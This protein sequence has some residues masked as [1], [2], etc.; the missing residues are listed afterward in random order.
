[1]IDKSIFREYDIRG[2]VPSQLNEASI[3]SISHAI[4]QKCNEENITELALGR[5]GRLSGENILNLLS[6]ELQSTGIN[7][8]N[9]GVVSSPL[10]YY[11]AKKLSSKSGIMITGS[12][13]PKNYNGLKIVINDSPIS[14]LEILNLLSDELIRKRNTG[15]EI[16]KKNLMDEYIKEVLSQ[17]SEKPKEIKVVLDCGNGSAG[18]IAPK[19]MRS[20]GYEVIELYCEIDG[21]FPNHHPDPG[22][23]E[24]LQ[25]LIK[26]VKEN[27]ADAGIAFDGDGD[28]LG[29]VTEE[30]DII[31]PDQ[32]MMIF[33]KD[34]LKS[35]PGR[36]I[37]FDV[38]CTNLLT[39][40]I[41]DAGGIPLMSPTGHF[42]I[43]NTLQKTN[44]PLAGEM[45][46]HIFFNDKWHG[47][48]DGHYSAYRLLEIMRCLDMP[49][50]S[51]LKQLPKAHST[52]E[53]NINVEE[54]NKFKIVKDFVN[55]AQFKGGSKI[56]I[57][58][59]RVD[60][61][62]GWGL[63]RASNTTPKLVLRF[64]AKTPSR[65]KE[66]KNLFL[67]QLKLIDETIQID[68]S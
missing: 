7:I 32:L 25:D 23:I 52:P 51:I 28:R 59:L 60:F 34:V 47:F 11:A 24:N 40:I 20:L 46:G 6:K 41:N 16:F 64:E 57:D 53:L 49:L 50:S 2:I 12:H 45:S 30:G 67:K 17:T 27:S 35:H 10:L 13:N 58:G 4:A 55:K 39:N 43:K 68:I 54:E 3:K 38:K 61:E 18:E 44:A 65:L 21:N 22:K 66:I 36:E 56:T 42:H 9:I 31:F 48:D 5:D 63:L 62:D 37:V 15:K 33:A 19:L 1:M 26:A 14:G 8:V 29:V